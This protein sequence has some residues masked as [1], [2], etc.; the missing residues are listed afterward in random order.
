[1]KTFQEIM[2]EENS[3]CVE[4]RVPGPCEYHIKLIVKKVLDQVNEPLAD[5]DIGLGEW[6]YGYKEG[7]KNHH[8]AVA[9]NIKKI[10]GE[11]YVVIHEMPIDPPEVF[12]G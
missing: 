5:F 10:L 9:A 2:E 12:K 8:K 7:E 1:M 3:D 6:E 4:G 11:D